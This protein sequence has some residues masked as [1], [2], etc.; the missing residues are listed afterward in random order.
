[1]SSAEVEKRFKKYKINNPEYSNYNSG[2]DM[3]AKLTD[4]QCEKLIKK[5]NNK[6]TFDIE[7]LILENEQS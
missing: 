5:I 4:E 7:K 6:F 1:M 2:P 3:S